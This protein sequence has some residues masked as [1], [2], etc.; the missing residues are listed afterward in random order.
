MSVVNDL[1]EYSRAE[2]LVEALP[3]ESGTVLDAVV[4]EAFWDGWYVLMACES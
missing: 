2:A 3:A 4:P 1:L